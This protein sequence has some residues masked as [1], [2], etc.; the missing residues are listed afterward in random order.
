MVRDV[1]SRIQMQKRYKYLPSVFKQS[2]YY[3]IIFSILF[4]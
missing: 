1:S 3:A 2:A 4:S